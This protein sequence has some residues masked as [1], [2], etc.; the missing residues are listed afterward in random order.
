[1]DRHLGTSH[2]QN[3]LI[4]IAFCKYCKDMNP[5]NMN[6]HTF[7]YYFIRNI[8]AID[9][10]NPKGRLYEGMDEKSRS[11]YNVF[12]IG[13]KLALANLLERNPTFEEA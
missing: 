5:D 13:L 12:A 1:M 2:L 6:E 8:I 3:T 4:C 10:L 9:R 11:F 7:M